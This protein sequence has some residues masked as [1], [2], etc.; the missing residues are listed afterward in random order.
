MSP[1]FAI[2]LFE[3]LIAGGKG[4][5]MCLLIEC[6]IAVFKMWIVCTE[7]R[8]NHIRIRRK[9]HNPIIYQPCH[10]ASRFYF[11]ADLYIFCQ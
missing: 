4:G 3:L 2:E 9:E 5:Y 1:I 7:F 8:L 6:L 11:F 10:T